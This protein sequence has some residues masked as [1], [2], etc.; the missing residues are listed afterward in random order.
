MKNFSV[1]LDIDGCVS[2][3]GSHT[4]YA[5]RLSNIENTFPITKLNPC[6]DRPAIER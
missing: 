5:Q 3:A 6:L 4:V 2:F 1:Y